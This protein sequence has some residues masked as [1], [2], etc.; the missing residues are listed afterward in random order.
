MTD[1]R[2]QIRQDALNERNQPNIVAGVL[3]VLALFLCCLGIYHVITY[4]I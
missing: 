3:F 4:W 2:E 1:K